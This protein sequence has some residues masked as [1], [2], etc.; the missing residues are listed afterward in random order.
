MGL[1]ASTV[2][3]FLRAYTTGQNWLKIPFNIFGG[4]NIQL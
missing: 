1:M 2:E 4:R 3:F